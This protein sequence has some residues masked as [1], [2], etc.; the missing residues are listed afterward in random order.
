MIATFIIETT[1]FIY[2]LTRYKLNTLSRLVAMIVGLLAIFQLA[3]YHVCE[4]SGTASAATWA[5]IGYVAITLIP[6]LAI[7]LIRT[8]AHRGWRPLV[9]LAYASAGF[10][11]LFFGFNKSAFASHICAGNYVIF[12]LEPRAGG[13]YFSYYYFWLLIGIALALFLSVKGSQKTR[14]ALVLQVVGYLTFLLPTA[15]VNTLNP[16]TISGIP[17]IMCGFAVLYAL[18]L[19]FG[20]VPRTLTRKTPKTSQAAA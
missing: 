7:H 17:S 3:E 12:Q 15:I 11:V 2:T 14:E 5:R 16:K 10:F 18:I 4:Y 1:L 6:A 13:I 9:G 8:I 19:V 20:I